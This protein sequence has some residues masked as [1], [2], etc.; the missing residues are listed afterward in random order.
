M[1]ILHL[2]VMKGIH[3]IDGLYLMVQ[4]FQTTG[5]RININKR[6]KFI[7]V[8]DTIKNTTPATLTRVC[9]IYKESTNKSDANINIDDTNSIAIGSTSNYSNTTNSNKFNITNSNIFNSDVV[10]TEE[11]IK[12]GFQLKELLGRK[13]IVFLFGRGGM[14]K[15]T[16]VKDFIKD[17]EIIYLNVCNEN[18]GSKYNVNDSNNF[19]SNSLNLNNYHINSWV[20]YIDNSC[21]K[22]FY[23]EEFDRASLREVELVR[24]F[25]K[26]KSIGELKFK[27]IKMVCS[28]DFKSS[29]ILS[30][31]FDNSHDDVYE[32]DICIEMKD[33]SNISG[34]FLIL[35]KEWKL[36]LELIYLSII[37]N[38]F[39]RHSH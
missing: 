11:Q 36:F 33:I 27:N 13:D 38:S 5:E 25:L 12:T 2:I 10:M 16:L 9:R 26:Y 20:D 37:L 39:I 32:S 28:L 8:T 19:E 22:L 31:A 6:D 3:V 15:K 18:K 24:E 7:F 35:F 1:T 14:G 23:I 30:N 17:K 29:E 34:F 21:N 4:Y